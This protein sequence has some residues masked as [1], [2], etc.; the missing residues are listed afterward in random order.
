MIFFFYGYDPFIRRPT[1]I[2]LPDKKSWFER[3]TLTLS[4]PW[5]LNNNNKTFHTI[6][7]IISLLII[8]LC[9][10]PLLAIENFL[11]N[12]VFFFFLFFKQ[13]RSPRKYPGYDF[14]SA[15][16]NLQKFVCIRII[17][18]NI[19]RGADSW[20]DADELYEETC[21]RRIFN[22]TDVFE[23]VRTNSM[24]ERGRE[25]NRNIPGRFRLSFSSPRFQKN[26]LNAPRISFTFQ[27]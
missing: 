14:P 27:R 15:S 7:I 5:T 21:A 18:Y 9:L 3:E 16:I 4:S 19:P 12:S 2:I 26:E 23:T 17:R 20:I 6:A 10:S 24:G 13:I 8:S 11:A 22:Q 25:G 1:G